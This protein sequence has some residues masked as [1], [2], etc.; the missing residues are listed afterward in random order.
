M[1][2]LSWVM[3]GVGMTL[4]LVGAAVVLVDLYRLT[5]PS[6]SGSTH[7]AADGR[8]EW[9]TPGAY[10]AKSEAELEAE[11]KRAIGN[12]TRERAERSR[13]DHDPDIRPEHLRGE[14][15]LG[16]TEDD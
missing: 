9:D 4:A 5:T 14:W 13:D 16:T 2:L 3:M 10:R 7:Q 11:L 12:H 15:T 8:I 1:S 6:V